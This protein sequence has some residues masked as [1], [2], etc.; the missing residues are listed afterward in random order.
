MDPDS[1]KHADPDPVIKKSRIL[2]HGLKLDDFTQIKVPKYR[3][4]MP[5]Y[6]FLLPY[7]SLR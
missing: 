5:V 1:P 3:Y 7:S 6:G 2:G 4:L